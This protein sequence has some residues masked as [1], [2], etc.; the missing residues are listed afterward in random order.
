MVTLLL[1]TR[2][3]SSLEKVHKYD[4]FSHRLGRMSLISPFFFFE[5]VNNNYNDVYH[6]RRLRT[7]WNKILLR[8]RFYQLFLLVVFD[9]L[10][11]TFSLSFWQHKINLKNYLY[12]CSQFFD[13]PQIRCYCSSLQRD[14]SKTA[15]NL[16]NTQLLYL[17]EFVNWFNWLFFKIECKIL[18]NNKILLFQLYLRIFIN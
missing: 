11:L 2:R 15:S 5:S 14:N 4:I 18:R 8:Y 6:V 10:S 7:N 3:N 17:Q 9:S 1:R 12:N 16:L 13:I